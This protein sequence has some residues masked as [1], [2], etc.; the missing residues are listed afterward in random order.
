MSF[1]WPMSLKVMAIQSDFGWTG[2]I[3]ISS[4]FQPLVLLLKKIWEELVLPIKFEGDKLQ[5]NCRF[6][7][8][9]FID[10]IVVVLSKL[11]NSYWI[12]KESNKTTNAM[13]QNT[14]TPSTTSILSVPS[15]APSMV[16]SDHPLPCLP[17]IQMSNTSSASSSKHHLEPEDD[18]N[19]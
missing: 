16:L 2:L 15:A 9:E 1:L 13:P 8:D 14:L 11:P 19:F 3:H 12:A 17:L 18:A 5:M 10:S 4:Y 6:T 7:H